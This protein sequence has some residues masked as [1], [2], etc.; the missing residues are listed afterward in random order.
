MDDI[1][2]IT[3]QLLQQSHCDYCHNIALE[4]FNIINRAQHHYTC[5]PLENEIASLSIGMNL[6]NNNI[7][8]VVVGTNLISMYT[9]LYYKM[10]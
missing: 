8:I 7:L 3:L 2:N 1:D 6:Y 4:H 9:I 10:M 5:V